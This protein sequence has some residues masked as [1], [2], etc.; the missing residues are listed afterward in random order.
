MR[1]TEAGARR[2]VFSSSPERQSRARK[3]AERCLHAATDASRGAIQRSDAR[4]RD[5]QAT[6]KPAGNLSLDSQVQPGAA[7]FSVEG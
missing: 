3:I 7:L 1:E 2:A 4:G 5:V 6:T